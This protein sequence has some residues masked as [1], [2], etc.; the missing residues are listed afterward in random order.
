MK[1]PQT[2]QA[3][4]PA[5]GEIFEAVAAAA[6]QQGYCPKCGGVVTIPQPPS[7]APDGIIAQSRKR[8]STT[9]L[10]WLLLGILCIFLGETSDGTVL[11]WLGGLILGALVFTWGLMVVVYLRAIAVAVTGENR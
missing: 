11:V 3:Q 10:L 7:S 5:C 9:A 6:G 1:N 8:L 2:V 4:C